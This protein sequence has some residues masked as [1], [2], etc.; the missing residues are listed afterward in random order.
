MMMASGEFNHFSEA[1]MKKLFFLLIFS[2]L[3]ISTTGCAI[4]MGPWHGKVIDAKTKQPIQGA[5][6]VAVFTKGYIAPGSYVGGVFLDAK[7]TLTDKNGEFKIPSVWYLEI[8]F[9]REVR[10]PEFTIFKPGYG[11]YPE[12]QVSPQATSSYFFQKGV[13]AT[14]VELPRITDKNKRL[15]ILRNTEGLDAPDN[16]IP[17]FI[18]LI[19]EENTNLG[20]RG[21]EK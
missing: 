19:N 15:E 11:S 17:E 10:F 4:E 7:E 5:A 2:I 14:P 6:V 3:L 21:R 8:P 12:Y 16:K 9:F 1:T 20:L 18:K 13:V